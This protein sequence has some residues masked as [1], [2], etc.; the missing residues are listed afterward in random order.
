LN[1]SLSPSGHNSTLEGRI[2]P[3]GPDHNTVARVMVYKD[4][5]GG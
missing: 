1:R 3:G 5:L 4:A 2:S